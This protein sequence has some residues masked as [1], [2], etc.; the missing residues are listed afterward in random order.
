MAGFGL[1]ADA[2][3][4]LERSRDWWDESE[5]GLGQRFLEDVSIGFDRL[6]RQ[7]E[8]G[9]RFARLD[10][11]RLLVRRFH[12]GIYCYLEGDVVRVVAVLDLRR[13]PR[14]IA[15]TLGRRA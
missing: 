8:L 6:K 11:R 13:D 10:Y 7:P 15:R 3:A 14:E 1:E 9:R 4:D 2:E 5:F 12:H